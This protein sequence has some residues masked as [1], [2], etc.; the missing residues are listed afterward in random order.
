M[1]AA[2]VT[3][4]AGPRPAAAAWQQGSIDSSSSLAIIDRPA[5]PTNL[6][7][8]GLRP[9]NLSASLDNKDTADPVCPRPD[10][11]AVCCRCRR[12]LLHAAAAACCSVGVPI[13]RSPARLI[14]RRLLAGGRPLLLSDGPLCRPV[15]L[16]LHARRV[17]GLQGA[18]HTEPRLGVHAHRS[19]GGGRLA[20]VGGRDALQR[21]SRP[22]LLPRLQPLRRQRLRVPLLLRQGGGPRTHN[23]GCGQRRPVGCP[24]CGCRQGGDRQPVPRCADIN[25]APNCPIPPQ[26]TN[27]TTAGRWV[28]LQAVP[29]AAA[30][31][32]T[33]GRPSSRPGSAAS[34][35]RPRPTGTAP[36]RA[37]SAVR[38]GCWRWSGRCGQ[39]P[40]VRHTSD[41][42]MYFPQRC[43]RHPADTPPRVCT[44][45]G[46]KPPRSRRP[47]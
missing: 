40:A 25:S 12:C 34:G 13:V 9:M 31:R 42:P 14:P 27:T 7:V 21:Q 37:A 43:C 23:R 4:L 41:G 5:N 32:T 33:T 1:L 8:Y 2:L 19:G 10:R 38:G 26:H 46:P 36:P 20:A 39:G 17:V 28:W 29:T 3:L 24:V 45:F 44:S 16:P 35:T 47:A 11:T 22:G 18:G 15:R 30:A 6:S